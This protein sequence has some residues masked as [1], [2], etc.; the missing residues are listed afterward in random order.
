MVVNVT[1]TPL[2]GS[3]ALDGNVDAAPSPSADTIGYLWASGTK[4][5][6]LYP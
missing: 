2:S 3:L 1:I 4:N 6:T 5:E